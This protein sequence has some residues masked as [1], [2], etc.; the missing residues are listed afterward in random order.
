VVPKTSS[1][2][3]NVACR[4]V[5]LGKGHERVCHVRKES[6]KFIV[7]NSTDANGYIIQGQP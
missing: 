3:L 5:S 4:S 1:L 7:Y 2:L 6:E